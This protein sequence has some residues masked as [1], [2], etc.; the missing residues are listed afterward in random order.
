MKNGPNGKTPKEKDELYEK[1]KKLI[2]KVLRDLHCNIKNVEQYEDYYSVA[3]LGLAKAINN[4]GGDWKNAK[5][6]YYYAYIRN[7]IINYFSYRS[8]P[9]RILLGTKMADIDEYPV[10]S[11]ID[12]ERD[13]IAKE[14]NQELYSAI[15][16]LK[17]SH[18][19]IIL[20]RFGIGREKMT[21]AQ[22]AEEEKISHQAVQ[23][24]QMYAIE[25]LRKELVRR[26]NEQKRKIVRFDCY[27]YF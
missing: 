14:T 9:K 1:Y 17:P 24:R 16:S 13:Y 19:D 26:E 18:R 7:E 2:N 11:G 22:I 25:K 27:K 3:Q 10:D 6:S 8:T 21:I 5:S 20:K 4:I 12:I 15:N 23:Q